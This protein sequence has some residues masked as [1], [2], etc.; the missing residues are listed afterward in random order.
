MSIADEIL[1]LKTSFDEVYAAG[2]AKGKTEGANGAILDAKITFMPLWVQS[3]NNLT[4]LTND[5]GTTNA[6]YDIDADAIR[7]TL[8]GNTTIKDP[9]VYHDA[10][11]YPVYVYTIKNNNAAL[12]VNI[13]FDFYVKG[14][15][16]VG[17]YKEIRTRQAHGVSLQRGETLQ[18]EI[19]TKDNG[20][21]TLNPQTLKTEFKI[22]GVFWYYGI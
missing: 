16:G 2:K 11:G 9:D 13:Y 18:F 4:R 20:G 6:A 15:D 22:V 14:T 12:A 17:N 3:Q 8:T 21:G 5:S 10:V 1:S 7:S 19:Y